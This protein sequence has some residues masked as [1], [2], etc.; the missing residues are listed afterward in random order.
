ME[1][2]HTSTR[3]ELNRLWQ[4][5][6]AWYAKSLD[7]IDIEQLTFAAAAIDRYKPK[8][9]VE[10]GVASGWTSAFLLKMAQKHHPD[11]ELHGIDIAEK[12]YFDETKT[13]G[14]ALLETFPELAPFYK[15]HLG[16]SALDAG[17]LLEDGFR[18][19][20]VFIDGNHAHPWP[21]VDLLCML[22]FIDHS[23]PV[24]LHDLEYFAPGGQGA[25]YLFDAWAHHKD[26]NL[27]GGKPLNIGIIELSD[28]QS[29]NINSLCAAL[30]LP[31][32]IFLVKKFRMDFDETYQE[33]LV[34]LL[35]ARLGSD[36][37]G[38]VRHSLSKAWTSYKENFYASRSL[39]DSLYLFDRNINANKMA[40]K[41]QALVDQKRHQ[42]AKSS[43]DNLNSEL[44]ASNQKYAK[45][46]S[47]LEAGIAALKKEFQAEL[48]L[49][50]EKNQS[51]VTAVKNAYNDLLCVVVKQKSAS[52]RTML[53]TLTRFLSNPVMFWQWRREKTI[54]ENSSEFDY[55]YYLAQN[56]GDQ[57]AFDDPVWHF[58]SEGCKQGRSPSASF[59]LPAYHKKN[60]DLGR[61]NPFAHY[62]AREYSTR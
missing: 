56:R 46:V 58:L 62:I 61:K 20:M 8:R 27:D 47:E 16:Y 19:D 40:V 6:P 45:Q 54:I 37:A 4:L 38:A 32:Q 10:I 21:T 30:E 1:V 18:A 44:V 17:E 23:I 52:F 49:T 48:N 24:I 39:A 35:K 5:A 53:N 59:D 3:E 7:E 22:P 33:K 50:R 36:A 12:V 31:W 28:D 41:N 51:E 42:A 9:I 2:C 26:Q 14:S 25:R 60:K 43:I 34:R 55:M 57:R 29:D 15:L 13:V 11:A